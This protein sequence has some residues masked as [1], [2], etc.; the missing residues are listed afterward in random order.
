MT[1]RQ[2]LALAEITRALDEQRST[3]DTLQSRAGVLLAA[4]AIVNVGLAQ[5]VFNGHKGLP[6]P[7]LT[8]SG[9]GCAAIGFA[10]LVSLAIPRAYKFHA[11][12]VLILDPKEPFD[13]TDDELV[14]GVVRAMSTV[15]ADNS[16]K[17]KHLTWTLQFAV[18]ALAANATTWAAAALIERW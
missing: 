18:A 13:V 16:T 1:R 6:L 12:A 14:P 15:H 11:P 8:I 5:V 7:G 10:A 3:V 2:D 17:L 9:I 4:G